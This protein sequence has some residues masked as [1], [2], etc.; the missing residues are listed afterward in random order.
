MDKEKRSATAHAT[1]NRK[2]ENKLR[3]INLTNKKNLE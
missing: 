1:F 2:E 3:F